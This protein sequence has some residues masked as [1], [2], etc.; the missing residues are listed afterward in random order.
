MLRKF[1]K[2]E[3]GFTLIEIL[4]VVI[5]IGLLASLVGPKLFSKVS[6]ARKSGRPS[7]SRT[8]TA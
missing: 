5:I 1:R 8:P 3:K 2:G 4:I 6:G 7:R